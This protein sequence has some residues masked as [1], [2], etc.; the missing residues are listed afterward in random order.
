MSGPHM[1]D[2]ASGHAGK[3]GSNGRNHA[4]GDAGDR[5]ARLDAGESIGAGTRFFATFIERPV[6]T[7][8]LTLAIVLAG[9]AA[10]G[11]LPVAPL[12]QVDYPTI[13]VSASLP[14]ASPETMA[15][16]VATPLER[17]LGK[18]AGVNQ[19]TSNSSLG[20]TRIVLQFDLERS[21]DAA[22]IDVQAAINAARAS[23]PA[24]L[25]RNPSYRKVNPAEDPILIIALTSES[26][27]QGQIYDIASTVLAQQLARVTGVGQVVVGGSSLPAVR[28]AVQPLQL[29]R[30]GIG[31][32]QV[33]QA[34]A[35]ASSNR[36]LGAVADEQT[37]WQIGTRAPTRTAADYLPLI[38]DYRDGAAVRLGD[39]ADVR[40]SVEDERNAGSANGRPSVLL[41]AYREPAA[42][43]IE[44][45]DRIHAMLPALQAA[46]P[47][48]LDMAVTSDRTTTIRASLRE[49]QRT[50][51][52]S[53]VL[54]VLVVFLFLRSARATLVP[55]IA[56]PTSLI[57]TFG[58]MYLAGYSLNNLSL[59]A[60]TVA[61]GF[62]V[63]DAI[64]V[65]ENIVR[66]REARGRPDEST[67]ETAIHGAREVG[68][69]VVAISLSLIAV[70]IPILAMGGLVGRYFREFAMVL[71]VAILISLV[72]SLTTTPMLAARLLG[73][74]GRSEESAPRTR[75][76]NDDA[77]NG[78]YPRIAHAYARSVGWA[79]D[80]RWFMLLVL[81]A[82]IALNVW[83]YMIVPKG[84]FPAQD[85]GRIFASVRADQS[86]SFQAMRPKLDAF[87]EIVRHDPAVGYVTAYTGGSRVNSGLMF[88]S[89]VPLAERGESTDQVIARLR[90]KTAH[91]PGARLFMV[92]Q[93]EIRIGARTS[94]SNFQYTLRS[95]D[96]GELRQW[97]PRIR[98]AMS[99]LP[100]LLDIDTDAEDKGSQITLTID[101]DAAARLGIDTRQITNLLNNAYG[102][103]QVATIHAPLNQYHVV[104]EVAAAFRDH[105]DDLDRLSLP[106]RQGE[107][108]PLAMFASWQPTTTPLGVSHQG[109]FV[110]STVSF[111]LAPGVSLSQATAAIS[112]AIARLG[113]PVSLQHGFEGTASAFQQSVANQPWLILAAIIAVYLVLGILYESLVHPVTILSTLPSAGVGALL[114]LMATGTEFTVIALI[115]VL[116][117]IG[118]VKKNA[119]LMID[120]AL[121]AE[122][123]DGLSPRD[124]IHRACRLR[125]RP[126][127]MTTMA[128]MLGALPLALGTGDG[129]ELRRPLGI[130]IVGGLAVS[131]LLTLYTTPVVYL[132]LDRL[133]LRARR[134]WSAGGRRGK[135]RQDIDRNGES[136]G[137]PG[138]GSDEGRIGP[139][140]PVP[141]GVRAL[142]PWLTVLGAL[143]LLAGC[144]SMPDYQRPDIEVGARY[145]EVVNQS[146]KNS[147]SP[148]G[149]KPDTASVPEALWQPAHSDAL[150]Q[151]PSWA[152]FGDPTLMTLLAA[153]E[154]TNQTLQMAQAQYRGAVAAVNAARAGRA[155]V[156]SAGAS[157]TR[158]RS[159]GGA[160]VQAWTTD[161]SAGWEPDLW[162]RIAARIDAAQA[163]AE[164]GAADL[165]G[166]RLAQQTLL[167]QTWFQW[168]VVRAQQ[169]L[170][171]E[172]VAAYARSLQLTRDR[173]AAGVVTR[174]DVAQ[175]QTQWKAAQAQR[176]ETDITRAQLE[177]A[178]ALLTGRTPS[179]FA[180]PN[181][182]VSEHTQ[183]TD[184]WLRA[185]PDRIPDV[186]VG[187]PS[188]LLERRPD[189][190]AAERRVAA[191]HARIGAARAAWYPSLTLGAGV[192]LRATTIG[193]LLALPAR[194]WSLGP[195]LAALLFDGG[196]RAADDEQAQAEYEFAVANWR[197]TVLLAFRE[198]E[199]QLAA[200]RVLETQIAVQREV[201][202]AAQLTLELITR[203]YKAGTVSF[204]NVVQ[205]QTS[206][207]QA[208]LALLSLQ[209]RR[210]DGT[211][212]LIRAIGGPW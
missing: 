190:I 19:M 97:E 124:A 63:D 73:A 113:P 33:R 2:R 65:L 164:A 152:A 54:V 201:L 158:A 179:G 49:V 45:V 15:A 79:L 134:W 120:F 24:G 11:L 48:A 209:G 175:A 177:H 137:R 84:F 178:L 38:V 39:V 150:P 108:V 142:M 181:P 203:Q 34:I 170:L 133:R 197:Q 125:F 14:G 87:V 147:H 85:T 157:A 104:L 141:G 8:L 160:T 191:A 101:R 173:L 146:D 169:Q 138:R 3:G 69:T 199:D 107:P 16:T 95:D 163:S 30:Y 23:L 166:V 47:A 121:A 118:I 26:M 10:W 12:P 13:S 78:I 77:P 126:I 109:G 183:T 140:S 145:Q 50:L 204:L 4:A 165:A 43:I 41:I 57:G 64:V 67:I 117:L 25:V 51:I 42:N 129:A 210:L 149:S 131:Q 161:L 198:V 46:A 76:G 156:L 83:L 200:L 5:I 188:Q 182:E 58:V 17:A 68:F 180:L 115:G 74:R 52:L 21:I 105:P 20:Q 86:I 130:A 9:L 187:L 127:L 168:R 92:G 40:D 208:G 123:N 211:V 116:L 112:R 202:A 171:D 96:L 193:D 80:H 94:S 35:D 206:V 55:A 28:V 122:R 81:A 82:T 22:A 106:N 176:L 114:A 155:P 71:S 151:E 32:D 103:R 31:L 102:Q 148:S 66:R 185:L 184:P 60:L 144:T 98:N 196:A 136:G 62:V 6:A 174:A 18:I 37:R 128:A 29:D 36:P 100:E 93:S 61:T 132:A 194:V 205:A 72:V 159:T 189:I 44:V 119:I 1:N 162:G 207:Q 135:D 186:P 153:L 53:V 70:F 143:C 56:V 99:R 89:L 154:P 90:R 110:A 75:R 7:T 59:M 212:A 192:G 139:G 111:N 91:V 195:S 88:I 167:A 27:T 172:T